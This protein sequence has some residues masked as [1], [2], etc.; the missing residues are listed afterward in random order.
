MEIG[1]TS[2]ISF[3]LFWYWKVIHWLSTHRCATFE[4]NRTIID[5]YGKLTLTYIFFDLQRL[6]WPLN[7]GQL[8]PAYVIVSRITTILMPVGSLYDDWFKS[9][10]HICEKW[11]CIF[12][13][14]DID[15][16]CIKF[17]IYHMFN[18]TKQMY[19]NR[20]NR[21]SI[22]NAMMIWM[23]ML[24]TKNALSFIMGQIVA[25]E[26]GVT[27]TVSLWLFFDIGHGH[28]CTIHTP[29]SQI[30]TKIGQELT[31]LENWPWPKKFW[32]PAL[33]KVIE[34]RS[35]MTYLCDSQSK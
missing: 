32:P 11:V 10:A 3:R 25:L 27:S 33:G 15:R 7:Q 34:P 5:N 2:I 21:T 13:D 6:E 16:I 26:T 20:D 1:I 8:W 28:S 30:W 24:L 12:C 31:I 18:W 35:N 14:L 19:I 23:L 4:Q 9:Y 22:F 17:V 29:V